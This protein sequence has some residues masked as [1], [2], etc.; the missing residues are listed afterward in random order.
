M[1]L[2]GLLLRVSCEFDSRR[3]CQNSVG[4]PGKIKGFRRFFIF[5]KKQQ[6]RKIT[7]FHNRPTN[8]FVIIDN[9]DERCIILLFN[10]NNLVKGAVHGNA[11]N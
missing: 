10:F 6:K 9:K 7:N 8:L 3:G 11:R 4:K 2:G 5:A 1:P